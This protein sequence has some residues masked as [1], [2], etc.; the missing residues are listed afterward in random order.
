[1]FDDIKDK[2]SPANFDVPALQQIAQAIFQTLGEQPRAAVSVMCSAV[3]DTRIAGL[4]TTL[5]HD[6]AEKGNFTKRLA[7]ALIA[8]EHTE[9]QRDK[10]ASSKG[11]SVLDASK[12]NRRNMGMI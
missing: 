6:G 9:Q 8:L 7:D 5:E 11:D 3:E 10:T 4:M 1:M 2:I 12:E